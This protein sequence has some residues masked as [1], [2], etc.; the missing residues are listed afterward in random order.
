MGWGAMGESLWLVVREVG[1]VGGEQRFRKVLPLASCPLSNLPSSTSQSPRAGESVA[2]D[3]PWRLGKLLRRRRSPAQVT[4]PRAPGYSVRPRVP[5]L[6]R[7]AP[8]SRS[9]RGFQMKKMVSGTFHSKN[10][11]S[12][13]L[14]LCPSLSILPPLHT[15]ASPRDI[16]HAGTNFSASFAAGA[17]G[18][19][20]SLTSRICET[21]R[22]G[23][24]TKR[25][26][27]HFPLQE[28]AVRAL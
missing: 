28:S 15:L 23:K 13:P 12:C 18:R 25:L 27:P 19:F 3:T 9:Q 8:T 6:E 2:P 14:S 20:C 7:I 24:S 4:A 21:L 22:S 17:D 11:F 16:G 1:E 26:S 5:P 10:S